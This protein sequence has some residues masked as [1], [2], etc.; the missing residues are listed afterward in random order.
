[1]N[2]TRWMGI[3]LLLPLVFAGIGRAQKP[4]VKGSKDYSLLTR[5]P[6]FYIYEYTEHEFDQAQVYVADKDTNVEGRKFE[7]RYVLNDGIPE[8]SRLQVM[9][10]YE[11]TIKQLGGVITYRRD[12]RFHARVERQGKRV[13]ILLNAYHPHDYYLTIVEEQGMRQDVQ[14]KAGA[15]MADINTTGHAAVYGIYFDTDQAV[16]KPES[17]P[18]LQEIAALLQGNAKLSVHLVGHTD[19]T[20]LFAHNMKLSE[21]RALAVVNAL[22]TQYG[23][24]AVRLKASGVGPLSPVASNRTDDGKAQNRR[25]ELVEQ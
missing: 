19:S 14:A 9:R 22:V 12:D 4:D 20:G 7:I 8:P 2:R 1:M 6:N 15:W 17:A 25:V 24:A 21:A 16:I 3:A 11:N 5:M 23:I 10:N 18:V 13:W